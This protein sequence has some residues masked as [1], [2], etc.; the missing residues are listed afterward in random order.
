[1]YIGVSEKGE[2]S[3][4]GTKKKNYSSVKNRE[5]YE[6]SV[7]NS[8]GKLVKKNKRATK[9]IYKG[10]SYGVSSHEEAPITSYTIVKHVKE[11]F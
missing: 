1:L 5:V 3:F 11:L 4:E 10:R 7:K 9:S 6:T 2:K 8:T